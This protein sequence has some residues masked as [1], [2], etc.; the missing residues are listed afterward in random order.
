MV[1]CVSAQVEFEDIEITRQNVT[2]PG[3]PADLDSVQASLLP[4]ELRAQLASATSSSEVTLPVQQFAY[5]NTS[6]QVTSDLDASLTLKNVTFA[7]HDPQ[8][9]LAFLRSV[10]LTVAKTNHP[11]DKRVILHYDADANTVSPEKLVVPIVGS[12][13]TLDPWQMD[14]SLFELT[15]SGT[16]DG[17]PRDPWA[18]DV[19]LSLAGEVEYNR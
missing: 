6:S 14:S 13:I 18:V 12:S 5:A 15:V 4:P 1:G 10:T 3:M 2:F 17:L 11:S 7:S 8:R 9:D 19:T 16:Y